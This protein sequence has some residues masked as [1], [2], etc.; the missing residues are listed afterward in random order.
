M[1]YDRFRLLCIIA[2]VTAFLAVSAI[3][4]LWADPAG[5]QSSGGCQLVE[6]SSGNVEEVCT[7]VTDDP[8][9]I[10]QTPDEPTPEELTALDEDADRSHQSPTTT[11]KP[12]PTPEELTALDEQFDYSHQPT[13]TPQPCSSCGTP[14]T[15]VPTSTTEA[16][17]T[18]VMPTIPQLALT[19]TSDIIL[20]GLIGAALMFLALGLIIVRAGARR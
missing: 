2:T 9:T 1:S 17:T 20:G 13:V 11:E 19:G 10:I 7:D 8:P 12:E 15:T 14:T 4:I 6:D 3:G 18:T 5:A 16:P